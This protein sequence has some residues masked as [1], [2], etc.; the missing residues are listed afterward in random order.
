MKKNVTI[1]ALIVLLLAHLQS[2]SQ[3]ANCSQ[4]VAGSNSDLNVNS[5]QTICIVSG[6]Q[7]GNVN[8]NGNGTL[9][10]G[11]DATLASNNLNNFNTGAIINIYGTV[12]FANA[13][14]F[15]GGNINN[16][17]KLI[18]GNNPNFNG[19]SIIT[20]FNGAVISLGQSTTL[21]KGR[22]Y[23]YGFIDA[24]AD[25]STNT[26]TSFFNVNRIH[27][28]GNFNP[29]GTVSNSGIIVANAF[30]NFN[31][32]EPFI[33]NCRLVAVKGF[34]NNNSKFENHGIIWVP[35]NEN[36]A[37]LIQVNSN[38]LNA[39][40]IRTP[41]IINNATLTNTKGSIRI[42]GSTTNNDAA[43]RNNSGGKIVG[44]NVGDASN[45]S[46][47]PPYSFDDNTGSI[48]ATY[49]LV[50]AYDT[51]STLYS[52]NCS[53]NYFGYS[54]SG[55]V[56][57]DP[58]GLTDN[59]IA[60]P[61]DG[62][63]LSEETM[64]ANLLNKN[65]GIA[66][67]S[68]SIDAATGGFFF[69][70]IAPADYI[71]S[72]STIPANVGKSGWDIKLPGGW[73]A[74]G[75]FL[76]AGEGSDDFVD[77]KLFVTV[78][79]ANIT[80]AK[81][82]IQEL[83]VAEERTV[84]LNKAVPDEKYTL[85]E[86]STSILPLEGNDPHDGV[87]GVDASFVITSLPANARLF[88]DGQEILNPVEIDE[89]FDLVV[90]SFGTFG[91]NPSIIPNYNPSLLKISFTDEFH[92]STKF[93]YSV[94]DAAGKYSAPA[95]YNIS[96]VV[97]LPI[98]I[99]NLKGTLNSNS[100]ESLL[101]WQIMGAD[102]LLNCTV[103]RSLDG[104]QFAA[105]TTIN[106]TGNGS[107]KYTDNFSTVLNTQSGQLIYY[108]LK[109]TTADGLI[110]YSNIIRLHLSKSG[111]VLI[112][113]NPARNQ[114]LISGIEEKTIVSLLDTQGKTLQQQA[115]ASNNVRINLA[116]YPTGIYYVK[117]IGQNNSVVTI[118]KIVKE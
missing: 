28:S 62:A 37:N 78:S 18:F 99:S 46:K 72:V 26:S 112:T 81:F 65:S 71:V 10:I 47:T 118:K 48:T 13:V 43:S 59:L 40:Y 3:C 29:G 111:D 50:S 116:A 30:I 108:R 58:N 69:A 9:C 73:I 83:P 93:T 92:G 49:S 39:G 44:G 117:I 57:N 101:T 27:I 55:N 105:I 61:A 63:D 106:A 107:L 110:Y 35:G 86:P 20:N 19:A 102:G 91:V 100:N 36:S 14:N 53:P 75:E 16:Y 51:T 32:G 115:S 103:E 68:V 38:L 66:V 23:N 113:P 56:Y 74:V 7:T 84:F 109:I 52:S 22:I 21:S 87:L 5:G 31:S 8:F 34:N 17:N 94:M 60:T 42:D 80:N 95:D 97:I 24:K 54:I 77:G 104:Q 15:G 90:P 64:Y 70:G 67:A 33:N 76:G 98:T 12:N 2:L 85:N 1:L 89:N 41:R 11:P 82:G 79:N 114:I 25:F 4:T 6:T 88:Y 96:A 45:V